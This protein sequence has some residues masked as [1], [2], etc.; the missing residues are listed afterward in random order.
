M[1]Y[2]YKLYFITICRIWWCH[3][4]R[5]LH[6]DCFRFDCN[7]SCTC[8]SSCLCEDLYS[9]YASTSFSL[10]PFY[11]F[12]ISPLLYLPYFFY[13]F[14]CTSVILFLCVLLHFLLSSSLS[15]LSLTLFS[16]GVLLFLLLYGTHIAVDGKS[17]HVFHLIF[18][19]MKGIRY[20]TSNLGCPVWSHRRSQSTT[21][22]R[23]GCRSEK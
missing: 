5:W 16:P 6:Y 9:W 2:Y 23:G 15:T 13:S 1:Y 4:H 20:D 22:N 3:Y 7:Y 21:Q 8:L 10:A 18:L 17:S 14:F 11:L 19:F 12:L